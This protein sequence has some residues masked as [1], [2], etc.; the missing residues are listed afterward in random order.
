KLQFEDGFFAFFVPYQGKITGAVY[1][2]RGH[3]LAIPRDPVEKQQLGYFLG[4]AMLDSDFS[5]AYMRFTGDTAV[6]LQRQ[7]ESAQIKPQTDAAFVRLWQPAVEARAPAHSL[8]LL[9]DALSRVSRPYFAAS[10]GG[11]QAGAFDFVYDEAR[12]ETEMFGQGKK[13]N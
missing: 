2:G 9:Y 12:E 3:I 8:R 10:L 11:V 5:T 6:E 7:F 13:S 4:A 1:S